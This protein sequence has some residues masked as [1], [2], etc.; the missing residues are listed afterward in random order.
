MKYKSDIS[1]DNT[2]YLIV[3]DELLDELVSIFYKIYLYYNR[4][5][6]TSQKHIVWPQFIG[7]VI[8]MMILAIII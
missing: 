7:S 3:M 6:L 4:N 8:Y 2:L 5:L 1:N